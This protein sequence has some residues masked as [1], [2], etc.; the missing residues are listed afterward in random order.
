LAIGLD[1]LLNVVLAGYPDETLSA[2]SHRKGWRLAW[3]INWLF[4]WQKD[5]D[6]KRNHCEQ[7]YDYEQGRNDLPPEYRGGGVE[8]KNPAPDET[9]GDGKRERRTENRF[10]GDCMEFSMGSPKKW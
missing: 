8:R 2:R 7:C 9:A 5:E 3:W 10:C 6:G 1:Q 4:F